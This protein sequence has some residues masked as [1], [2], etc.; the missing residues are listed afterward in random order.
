[1]EVLHWTFDDTAFARD[2]L[3]AEVVEDEILAIQHSCV[4]LDLTLELP[5]QLKVG[6]AEDVDRQ[7][8]VERSDPASVDTEEEA[9][10]LC[11]I[12]LLDI[13]ARF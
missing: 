5:H 2:R 7:V 4:V 13:G 12:L 10:L 1:M 11:E 3:V 9:E 6:M 8:V